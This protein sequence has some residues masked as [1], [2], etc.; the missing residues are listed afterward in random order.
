MAQVQIMPGTK[1]TVQRGDSLS[2][3]AQRAYN[4]ANRWRLIYDANKDVIGPD[5]DIL[6][7]GQVLFIPA[8]TC[9]VTAA[10]GLN[11]RTAPNTQASIVSRQ[12]AGTVLNYIE[13]VGGEKVEGNDRW[14]HSQQNHYFWLGGTDRP[15]G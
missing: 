9:K 2:S 13:V 1:Y 15:N 5:P 8:M 7:P 14:G 4:D 10:N 6:H 12:P 11:I 3:I